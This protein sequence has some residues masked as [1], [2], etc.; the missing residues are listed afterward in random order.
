MREPR[1]GRERQTF[2]LGI[3]PIMGNCTGCFLKDQ[4]DL[5]RALQDAETD[6]DWWIWMENRWPGWGGKNFASYAQLR[7]EG[8]LRLKIEADLR[9][10]KIPVNDGL[11]SDRR[12]KLV[13]IQ[14]RKRLAGQVVPFACGCEGSEAAASLDT[15]EEE[16][17]LLS[18]T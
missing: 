3:D 11:L 8:P 14:E 9:E 18:L 1:G 7:S 2:K 12:F 5:S 13:V 16:A 17:W 6:A 15:E 10:S 4:S